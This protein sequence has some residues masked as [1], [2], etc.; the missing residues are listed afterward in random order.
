MVFRFSG[1]YHFW[2][3]GVLL[4]YDCLVALVYAAR[5]GDI[6]AVR[7]TP[8]RPS[9]RFLA[10]IVVTTAL[11]CFGMNLFYHYGAWTCLYVLQY[12]PV[13][14]PLYTAYFL[15]GIY[16]YTHGWFAEGYRPRLRPWAPIYVVSLLVYLTLIGA[17]GGDPA[18]LRGKLLINFVAGVEVLSA[19]LTLLA[20]FQRLERHARPWLRRA[21]DLS[22]GAYVVHLNVVFALVYLT[23]NVAV[24]PLF[25]RYVLQVVVAVLGAWGVAFAWRRLTAAEGQRGGWFV[26]PYRAHRL[27]IPAPRRP[28]HPP[29]DS[30]SLVHQAPYFQP[31]DFIAGRRD[32]ERAMDG[33]YAGA[34]RPCRRTCHGW[35]VRRRR[36]GH[37]GERAMDGLYAGAGAAMPANVPW[38]D[39]TPAPAR[40]CRRTCHGWI[41]HRRP[42]TRRSSFHATPA[43]GTARR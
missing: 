24:L 16:A 18:T 39:C 21:S 14:A 9:R 15:L 27:T 19:L 23:R 3:L 6:A 37:A 13:K 31:G 17:S 29:R 41:A 30:A 42:T 20:L 1:Q 11:L 33:L 36:R 28:S 32:G 35:I 43:V 40:P 22:F 25:P 7:I 5:Q 10:G 26:V 38:M 12:Q 34:A 4:L 8:G 2:Y